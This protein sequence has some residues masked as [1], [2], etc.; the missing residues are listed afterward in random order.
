MWVFDKLVA[1]LGLDPF[2][3]LLVT[4]LGLLGWTW[5]SVIGDFALT[6]RGVWIRWVALL[7]AGVG[8]L[9]FW[10]SIGMLA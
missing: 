6:G 9:L 4:I 3:Y 7:I 10:H 5:S 8:A 2:V 1:Q